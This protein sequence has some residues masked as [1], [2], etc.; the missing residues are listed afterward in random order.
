M[1]DWL[2]S[3]QQQ[4]AR[5]LD[6]KAHFADEKPDM[7]KLRADIGKACDAFDDARSELEDAIQDLENAITTFEKGASRPIAR[8]MRTR[9]RHGDH[10]CGGESECTDQQRLLH[11]GVES[12]TART[13]AARFPGPPGLV[14]AAVL[15]SR[16]IDGRRRDIGA[17]A[18][19]RRIDAGLARSGVVVST[20]AA[21]ERADEPTWRLG[22]GPQQ[23]LEVAL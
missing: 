14:R 16:S 4:A 20:S 2:Q 10:G 23:A 7:E 8:L 15:L 3:C 11:S 13:A 12:D 22:L 1:S 9:K 5:S 6:N 17:R 18:C 21:R 19:D